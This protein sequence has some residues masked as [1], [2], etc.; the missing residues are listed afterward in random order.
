[1]NRRKHSGK[2]RSYQLDDSGPGHRCRADLPG[3]VRVVRFQ[4]HRQHDGERVGDDRGHV[5]AVNV[6]GDVGSRFAARQAFGEQDQARA[7]RSE[8]RARSPAASG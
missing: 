5:V 6:R 7:S 4:I 1:M 2:G 8:N 3:P